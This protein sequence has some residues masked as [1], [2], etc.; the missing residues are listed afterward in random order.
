[1]VNSAGVKRLEEYLETIYDIVLKKGYA[2]VVDVSKALN[3]SPPTVTEMFKK[4][5]EEGYI[6]YI[7][8]S[9]VT[10]TKKGEAVAKH[11]RAR[12]KTIKNFLLMLG[13]DNA[14]A[15]EDA[16]KIEHIVSDKTVERLSEFVKFM[17]SKE[18][19]KALKAF[20]EHR[21]L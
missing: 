12:H 6:E 13:L 11:L 15:D 8:Y 14:V 19:K 17:L 20:M 7:K 4:L 1:M 5:D 10:L 3:L 9:G 16:C 18:G 2:K 21:Q